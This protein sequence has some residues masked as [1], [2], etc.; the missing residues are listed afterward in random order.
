[1]ALDKPLCYGG[2][3]PVEFRR[4][5]TRFTQ[6][7]DKLPAKAIEHGTKV[8]IVYRREVFCRLGDHLQDGRPDLACQEGLASCSAPAFLADQRH[9]HHAT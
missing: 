7:N 3:S 5:V 4:A 8:L 9:K 2:A 6:K 1:M